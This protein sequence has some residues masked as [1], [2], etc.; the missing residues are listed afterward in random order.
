MLGRLVRKSNAM[1][2]FASVFI[3]FQ[4]LVPSSKKMKI[5]LGNPVE[6]WPTTF[7]LSRPLP[8]TFCCWKPR[9]VVG[10]LLFLASRPVVAARLQF[11]ATEGKAEHG[12]TIQGIYA[13]I[14]SL[15]MLVTQRDML[16]GSRTI[17]RAFPCVMAQKPSVPFNENACNTQMS[18]KTPSC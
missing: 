1:S 13:P 17:N 6:G 14:M 15:I 4:K 5:H 8:T 12:N 7:G 18:T 16:L 2:R 3:C 10:Q 9:K 11:S